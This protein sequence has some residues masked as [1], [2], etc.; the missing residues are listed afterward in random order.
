MHKNSEI[1]FVGQS[2]FEQIIDLVQKVD[3]Q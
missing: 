2:I 3:I 1:K